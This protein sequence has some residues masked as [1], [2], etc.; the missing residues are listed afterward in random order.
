MLTFLVLGLFGVGVVKRFVLTAEASITQEREGLSSRCLRLGIKCSTVALLGG[1]K[2]DDKMVEGYLHRFAG[3]SV[4]VGEEAQMSTG[5]KRAP[6][7]PSEITRTTADGRTV[8]D[9]R[10]L[11]DEEHVKETF[12]RIQDKI[13]IVRRPKRTAASGNES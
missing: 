2:G 7:V 9:V 6:E 8:V 11:L 5:T 4:K 13:V 10:R 1:R 3:T 12:R